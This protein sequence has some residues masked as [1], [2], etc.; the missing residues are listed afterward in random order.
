MRIFRK[1]SLL[2]GVIAL[3]GSIPLLHSEPSQETAED[4]SAP[5]ADPVLRLDPSGR[6]D[7]DARNAA[8]HLLG[9]LPG[10]LQRL[11][12]EYA[13]DSETGSR[14][15]VET[16]QPLHQTPGAERTLFVQGRLSREDG[17][18][19][20]NLGL[21]WRQLL[22]DRSWLLGFNLFHDISFDAHHRRLGAGLEAIGP[23]LTLR[24]NGYLGI[25]GWRDVGGGY[26]ERALDGADA[27]IEGP[28][29]HLPWLRL[30]AGTYYWHVRT[31]D[32]LKGLR[33]RARMR[34]TSLF[35]LEAGYA[36]DEEDDALFLKLQLH[37]VKGEEARRA[38][39]RRLWSSRS[40]VA[41]D[42]AD[43]ALAFVER[44]NRIAVER[45]RIGG[46]SGTASVVVARGS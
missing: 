29:P 18:T 5:P 44:A 22:E 11:R 39:S 12:A 7:L 25:T 23:L 9:E 41:R 20:L 10:W 24:A 6:L 27:E 30:S 38:A 16:I 8:R 32:D 26:E 31:G 15:S 42:P 40:F 45:R 1:E 2:A 46:G 19:T 33:A 3:L 4:P 43:H 28:V 37:P 36:V 21:G 34:L 13:W 14:F 35:E 17:D